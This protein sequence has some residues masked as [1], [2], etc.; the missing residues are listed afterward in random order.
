MKRK[1]KPKGD[2]C[3]GCSYEKAR[4]DHVLCASCNNNINNAFDLKLNEKRGR[5]RKPDQ[6]VF[7]RRV[8]KEE[9]EK[10]DRYLEEIRK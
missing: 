4:Y 5:P 10:L 8:T 6:V 1:D 9:K 3:G 2:N 7:Y